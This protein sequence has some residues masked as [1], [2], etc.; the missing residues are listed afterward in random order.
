MEKG[1]AYKQ[2]E[3]FYDPF[4]CG[5]AGERGADGLP[6]QL[7]ICPTLGLTGFAVYKKVKDYSEPGY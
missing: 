6:E 4:V 1:E 2:L 7:F 3:L 5:E